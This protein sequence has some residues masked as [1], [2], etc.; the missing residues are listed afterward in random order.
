M[1]HWKVSCAALVLAS[2][3]WTAP[4]EA[5][6]YSGED[7]FRACTVE[8]GQKNYVERTYECI[9]Y[10]SG[11]VDAMNTAREAD[12]QKR[13]IPP[14]VTIGDLKRVSVDYLGRDG[15]DRS[16]SGS[17]LVMAAVGKEWPCPVEK[18]KVV[19]SKKR[20]R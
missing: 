3:T 12:K 11:V 20:R 5:G 13:C 8:R 18:K 2:S 1:R 9:A 6:F 4:A 14:E 16:V 15:V 17:R 10:V 19:K 7:L